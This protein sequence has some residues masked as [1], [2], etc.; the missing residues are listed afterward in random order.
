MGGT[1]NSS[2][3]F[4]EEEIPCQELILVGTLNRPVVFVRNQCPVTIMQEVTV[5]PSHVEYSGRLRY[6]T[7]RICT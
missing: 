6:D 2:E 3:R 5:R 1:R 4:D 7:L